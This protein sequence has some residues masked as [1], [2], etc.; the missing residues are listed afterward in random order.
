MKY[1]LNK[2][3]TTSAKFYYVPQTKTVNGA[4]KVV[5]ERNAMTLAPKTVY[6]TDDKAML[7]YLRKQTALVR[8]NAETERALKENGV[9][10]SIE[11][12]RS[13]SGRVK[14]IRYNLVEVFDE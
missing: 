8:Y 5:C 1:R 9:E 13:C 7:E 3:E 11:M 4:E 14:K 10:Y 2:A 12:C 6:E